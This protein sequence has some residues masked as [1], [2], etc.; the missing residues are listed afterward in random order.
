LLDEPVEPA[1]RHPVVFFDFPDGRVH[2]VGRRRDVLSLRLLRLDALVD[3]RAQDLRLQASA[4]FIRVRQPRRQDRQP[5]AV[6]EVVDRDHLVVDDR[7]D[8]L[9]LL[10]AQLWR[11]CGEAGQE[12]K[13]G[14]GEAEVHAGGVAVGNW[15]C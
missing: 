5:R 11:R 9:R 7:R 3:Q 15:N 4:G 2:L 13:D 1:G 12:R 14:Q 6:D 10:R 8:A